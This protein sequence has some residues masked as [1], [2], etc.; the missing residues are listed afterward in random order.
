MALHPLCVDPAGRHVGRV[1][2][3]Y[4]VDH[5][6]PHKGDP[7]LFWDRKNWQTLCQAC[8]A[9]KSATEQGGRADRRRINAQKQGGGIDSDGR[10]VMPVYKNRATK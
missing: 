4:Q 6:V 7:K 1:E 2:P 3:G 5:I 9:Y 8:G 10:I